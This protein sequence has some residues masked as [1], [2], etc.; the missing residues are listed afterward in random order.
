MNSD[1]LIFEIIRDE[2]IENYGYNCFLS[3]K[4]IVRDKIAKLQP[5]KPVDQTSGFIAFNVPNKDRMK[6]KTNRFLTRKL[7]LNSG[8]LSDK[9]ICKIADKINNE[10]FGNDGIIIELVSG[11]EITKHYRRETGSHSCMTG[12]HSDYTQL[13]E[14]NPD[15]FSMLV[16]FWQN[17]SARAIVSKLDGGSFYMDRIYSSCDFL[18][19]KMI[20]YANNQGWKCY[21][22]QDYDEDMTISNL[23]YEDGHIPYMD[24]FNRGCTCNSGLT[25]STCGCCDYDLDNTDGYLFGG[26]SCEFCGEHVNEDDCYFA[27]DRCLCQSCYDENYSQCDNCGNVEDNDNITYIEDTHKDVCENCRD[28]NYVCCEDCYKYFE[29]DYIIGVDGYTHCNNCAEGEY[30]PCKDCGEI[31]HID[32]LEDGYCESCKPEDEC[33]PIS[34]KPEDTGGLF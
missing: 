27:D 25:I 19:E 17:D 10:L 33:L 8:F 31:Y 32:D 12:G 28:R 20:N 30:Y 9:V 14:M 2:I 16:M 22:N 26:N 5:D 34:C 18:Q 29:D 6:L 11:E 13:Y 1:N 4:Y 24:T 3:R 23:S 7:N 15:R 21:D